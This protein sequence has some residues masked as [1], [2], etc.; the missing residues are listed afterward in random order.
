MA[1]TVLPAVES[2]IPAAFEKIVGCCD[3]WTAVLIAKAFREMIAQISNRMI[4]GLAL[5]RN[6]EW[7]RTS[8]NFTTDSFL[9]AQKLK[10]YPKI[11]RPV[12]ARTL[13]EMAVVRRH[14][15][16]AQRTIKPLLAQREHD[17]GDPE[18]K[19]KP[20]DLLQ[21]LTDGAQGA[22]RSHDFLAYTTL[23][24]SFAAIHTSASIPAHLVFDLCT[25]PE[26]I[27]P[28]RDEVIDIMKQDGAFT[29]PS[30]AKM[31]KMDSF[32]KESQRFSPLVFSKQP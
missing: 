19:G 25:R 29:K 14:I 3:D 10:K 26:C 27:R 8:L 21:M 5:C 32:M 11:L 30:I 2:E 1:A 4:G 9:A 22:D 7:L 24:V 15:E 31:V 13:K 28:L 20:T 16:V 12:M 23:A 18:S 6:E 17:L